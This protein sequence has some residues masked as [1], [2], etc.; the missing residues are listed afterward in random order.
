MLSSR[1]HVSPKSS[2]KRF[3][4]FAPWAY[5]ET[6]DLTS[7]T[8][9]ELLQLS[10]TLVYMVAEDTGQTR[11]QVAAD[12]SAGRSFTAPEA[13]DYGFVDRVVEPLERG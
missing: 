11:D 6:E 12:V 1:T 9:D 10:A 13:I 2:S 5:L 8:Q 4:A 3:T 7:A